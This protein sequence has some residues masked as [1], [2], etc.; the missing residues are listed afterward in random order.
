MHR[1]VTDA[2]NESEDERIKMK[3]LQGSTPVVYEL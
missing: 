3:S 1:C 2:A